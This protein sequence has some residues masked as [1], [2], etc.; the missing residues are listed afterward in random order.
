M[1]NGRRRTGAVG[2]GLSSEDDTF[3]NVVAHLLIGRFNLRR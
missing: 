2:L 1:G 3:C